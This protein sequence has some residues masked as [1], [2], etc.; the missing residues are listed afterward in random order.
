MKRR[1]GT[2]M[3]NRR[4]RSRAVLGAVLI[5]LAS[6]A[7]PLA[8]GA[9]SESKTTDRANEAPLGGEAL[10]QRKQDL[11][12]A[13]GDLGAFNRTMTSLIER[14]DDGGIDAMEPFVQGYLGQH[15]DPL[16]RPEWTSDHPEVAAIDA[17]LRFMKA[18]LLIQMRQTR[19]V[20]RVLDDIRARY[21]DRGQMLVEYPLGQQTTITQAIEKLKT[22][23]WNG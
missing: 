16:I 19:Q 4:T 23:K 18:E 7:M 6:A 10:A 15:L 21:A 5:A 17:N 9:R 14:S 8:A 13:L 12:R 3:Q 11:K 1:G 2:T 20:Q 22:R